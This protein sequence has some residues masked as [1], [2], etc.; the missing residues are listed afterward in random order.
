MGKSTRWKARVATPQ[1][2]KSKM[3]GKV[4]VNDPSRKPSAKHDSVR[5]A[6]RARATAQAA[7]LP[8]PVTAKPP[9]KVVNNLDQFG[10]PLT[11]DNDSTFDGGAEAPIS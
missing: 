11:P 4:H 9:S 6:T 10:N 3:K 1:D 7:A 8:G 2:V 5:K